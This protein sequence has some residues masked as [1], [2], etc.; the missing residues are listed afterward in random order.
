MFK[1]IAIKPAYQPQE[2]PEP[3]FDIIRE[4]SAQKSNN[5]DSS[6][7]LYIKRKAKDHIFE[8]IGWKNSTS[9]NTVEQGGLLVGNVFYD[10]NQNFTYGI[11]EAAFAAKYAIG[12]SAHLR[13]DHNT[14]KYMYDELDYFLDLYPE[15][16]F[17][18]IGWY[19]THPNQLPVFMSSI[20]KD[21]QQ[22][23]FPNHWQFAVVLNPHHTIWR[24]YHGAECENCMGH[25][26][27]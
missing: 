5:Y 18:I 4:L 14:W 17:Q 26:L 15:L 11:V 25:F 9:N 3:V 23:V 13:M 8:H 1:I 12:S 7:K 24:A 16:N 10:P 21:T 19:H 6:Y 27:K 22:S 20:D 2:Q